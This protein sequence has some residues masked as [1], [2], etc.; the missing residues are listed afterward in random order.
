MHFL[1]VASARPV[2]AENPDI[3]KCK[4]GKKGVLKSKSLRKQICFKIQLYVGI[5]LT[6]KVFGPRFS[7]LDFI[8]VVF[9]GVLG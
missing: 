3:S 1:P 9:F 8:P 5:H 7:V 2:S 4:F 6:W